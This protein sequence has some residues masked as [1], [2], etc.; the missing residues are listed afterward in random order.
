MDLIARTATRDSRPLV[1]RN[2]QFELL[3]FLA[4]HKNEV[5]T[6]DM[7]ASEVWRQSTATW[8]NV[9]EVHINHLRKEL[10]RP[11]LPTLLHTIRGQGYLLGDAP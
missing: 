7:I 2:R 8:T 11:G 6:R 10:E 4:R 9:I 3:A 5:V 1:L